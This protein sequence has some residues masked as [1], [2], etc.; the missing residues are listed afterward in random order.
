MNINIKFII[1]KQ[2]FHKKQNILMIQI[3]TLKKKTK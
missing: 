3:V 2:Q 1:D